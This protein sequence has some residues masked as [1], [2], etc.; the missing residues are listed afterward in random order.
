AGR[1]ITGLGLTTSDLPLDRRGGLGSS[2]GRPRGPGVGE[3]LLV[4]DEVAA[5][6]GQAVLQRS[7]AGQGARQPLLGLRDGVGEL[8]RC[9]SVGRGPA[10]QAFVL[11]W[12]LSSPTRRCFRASLCRRP[13]TGGLAAT[14]WPVRPAD[15]GPGP[16]CLRPRQPCETRST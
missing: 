6:P 2:S 11:S 14:A 12:V 13:G 4:S 9:L 3:R 16:A 1:E 15:T 10:R 7:D 5:V 8:G